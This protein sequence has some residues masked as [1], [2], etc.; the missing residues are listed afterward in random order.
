MTDRTADTLTNLLAV[1]ADDEALAWLP[2][3]TRRVAVALAELLEERGYL[4]SHQPFVGT[5]PSQ[6][7]D[8]GAGPP[9]VVNLDDLNRRHD[10]QWDD[11]G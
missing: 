6:H 5:D 4:I 2:S 10:S 1:V 3:T 11:D 8:R 7:S 9:G